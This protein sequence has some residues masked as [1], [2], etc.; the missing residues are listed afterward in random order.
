[1]CV[2]VCVCVCMCVCV[3]VCVCACMCVCVSVCVQR[4]PRVCMFVCACMYVCVFMV[5]VAAISIAKFLFLLRHASYSSSYIRTTHPHTCT[6]ACT[7]LPHSP[8]HTSHKHNM[9]HGGLPRVVLNCWSSSSMRL[10]CLAMGSPSKQSWRYT[11]SS[12][13]FLYHPGNVTQ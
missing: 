11:S 13:P 4:H 2:W 10:G 3:C 1:M 12:V 7:H 6:H 8:R 5:Q 9:L